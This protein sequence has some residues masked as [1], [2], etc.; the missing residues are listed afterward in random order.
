MSRQ[1][2]AE[3]ETLFSRVPLMRPDNLVPA[4]TPHRYWMVDA[5]VIPDSA[6][7]YVCRG[8]ALEWLA[9]K[10]GATLHHWRD[11]WHVDQRGQ[12]GTV[13]IAD[14]DTLDAAVLAAC[15]RLTG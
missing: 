13:P 15:N 6:A 4:R 14:A 3:Y 1:T 12:S 7:V 2:L 8:V 9:V 10:H 11:R 5:V